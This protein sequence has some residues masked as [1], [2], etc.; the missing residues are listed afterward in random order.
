MPTEHGSDLPG[1]NG[2]RLFIEKVRE[3]KLVPNAELDKALQENRA[4]YLAPQDEDE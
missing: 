2:Y 4:G 3:G 1:S